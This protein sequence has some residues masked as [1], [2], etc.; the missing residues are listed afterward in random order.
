MSSRS[1]TVLVASIPAALSRR[2]LRAEF[3]VGAYVRFTDAVRIVTAWRKAGATEARA[4]R[5]IDDFVR[6]SFDAG[7]PRAMALRI[8]KGR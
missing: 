3:A 8:R 7:Y 2:F 6:Y 4:A 5:A 1:L